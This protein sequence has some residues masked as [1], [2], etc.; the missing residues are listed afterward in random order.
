MPVPL[1]EG[2][3]R[4]RALLVDAALVKAVGAGRRRGSAEEV[5]AE[6]V[7][8]RLVDL[9]AGTHLQLVWRT[10]ARITTR[11]V[12]IADG[13]ALAEVV[14]DALSRP[15]AN[16]HVETES[17]TLQLRVTK[18][19]EAQVHSGAT[20]RRSVEARPATRAHDRAKHRL[21]DPDDPL[22]TV[23]GADA[24]KRRQVDAFLRILDPVVRKA[25]P[26]DRPLRVVDLGCGNAYLTMA[27]HRFLSDRRPGTVTVGVELRVDL[28]D[29][30]AQ[31]AAEAG[32][33]GLRFVDGAIA[34]A[35]TGLDGVDVV[36][37]LHACDTATDEALA[38]AIAWHAPVILAA[39][40][41]HHDIQRQLAGQGGAP[42]PAPY[43]QI[44]SHPILRERFADVLTDALRAGIL[45]QHGYRVDVVEF[46]DSRHTPRN[47]LIRARRT[48]AEPTADQVAAHS[49]LC[50]QWQVTPAL[51]AMVADRRPATAR[52]PPSAE[53]TG[54]PHARS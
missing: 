54:P 45:R 14:D 11:N 17:T 44:T 48:G 13:V 34:S 28:V 33:D 51:S 9:A 1:A 12:P 40:C 18:R 10:G 21:V 16:W 3:A 26:D 47:A 53:K 30:S 43:R 38:R 37:A 8:L 23:L 36:L 29:R 42:G 6:R 50:A 4:V 7:D 27:A 31:R 5:L 22:F 39:P 2:L 49:E 35:D 52:T 19:G 24:D 25:F 32:L 15:F 41:C 46:V 20:S